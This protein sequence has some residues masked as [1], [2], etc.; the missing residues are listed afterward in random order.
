MADYSGAR[1]CSEMMVD[2][3]A[4]AQVQYKR[5]RQV[6]ITSK[7]QVIQAR[8]KV[9]YR[10]QHLGTITIQAIQARAYHKNMIQIQYLNGTKALRRPQAAV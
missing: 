2:L 4:S 9:Q 7:I 8:A 10:R 3:E 1:G 5:K 6:C